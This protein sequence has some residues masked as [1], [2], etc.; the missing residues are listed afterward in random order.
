[1][2]NTVQI[3]FTLRK[4]L[5]SYI[6]MKRALIITTSIMNSRCNIEN[7]CL[8]I[9]KK[10][11][12][13]QVSNMTKHMLRSIKWKKTYKFEIL[14][15]SHSK[16]DN[17]TLKNYFEVRKINHN[18]CFVHSTIRGAS[19]S[20]YFIHFKMPKSI[21]FTKYIF[22]FYFILVSLSTLSYSKLGL[23]L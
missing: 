13:L 5:C 15:H 16:F 6:L 23:N 4:T 12:Q 21:L 8:M 9:K 11:L 14:L 2:K 18:W 1:M 20:S 22:L 10:F 3:T 19:C 17:K 7:L